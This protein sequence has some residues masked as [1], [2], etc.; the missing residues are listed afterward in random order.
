MGGN[1]F[2]PYI[3]LTVKGAP[4]SQKQILLGIIFDMSGVAGRSYVELVVWPA[5]EE[6]MRAWIWSPCM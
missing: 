4:M 6:L 3:M 2:P 1:V 5:V